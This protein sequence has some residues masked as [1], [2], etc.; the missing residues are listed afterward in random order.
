MIAF[1]IDRK[2][3]HAA[4]WMLAAS[5]FSAVGLMHAYKITPNG[6]ENHFAWFTAAPDFAIA[7]AVGAALLLVAG[8]RGKTEGE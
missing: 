1:V 8:W 6:V 3:K 2:F 4:G 5:F 7:Y